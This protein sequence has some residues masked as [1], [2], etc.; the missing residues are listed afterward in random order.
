MDGR[1]DLVV[2]RPG[3]NGKTFWQ[4]LGALWIK[5]GKISIKLDAVPVGLVSGPNNSEVPFGGWIKVFEAKDN[6][7]GGSR[8][9][10]SSGGGKT[11]VD[12]DDI[13]Y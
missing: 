13:P 3:S 7:G 8:S 11:T 6:S 9:G 4:K 5:D 2:P 1:Y 12:D 10:G